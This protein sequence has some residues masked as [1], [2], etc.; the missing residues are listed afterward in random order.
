MKQILFL[1]IL[2]NTLLLSETITN[3]TSEPM[4]CQVNYPA[5]F[6]K[7]LVHNIEQRVMVQKKEEFSLVL[8]PK[9]S[10][11]KA[12]KGS[13]VCFNSLQKISVYSNGIRTE[14]GRYFENFKKEQEAFDIG[15]YAN[16]NREFV[17]AKFGIHRKCTSLEEGEYCQLRNGLDILYTKRGRVKKLLIYGQALYDLDFQ[18]GS[19]H[20]IKAGRNPLGLWVAKKNKKLVSAKPSFQSSN[21]IVWKNPHKYIKSIVLTAKNGHLNLYNYRYKKED[22]KKKTPKDQLGAIEVEY[23]LDDAAYKKH[24]AS[25]PMPQTS[26]PTHNRIDKI[27]LPKK[28]KKTWG[29]YLNPKN[30]IPINKFKAFYIDTNHPKKLIASEIV[31]KVAVNYPWKDFHNIDA[32]NFG[33]Y[34]VGNFIFKETKEQELSVSQ[35]W[36]RTRVIIDGMVVY[37]GGSNKKFKHKF[38]KGKHKI[39]VEYVNNWHTVGFMFTMKDK[40]KLYSIGEIQKELQQKTSKNSVV[41]FAGA[42]ESKRKDQSITL[43]LARS[44]KPVVLVLN[45]YDAVRWIIKNPYKVKLQA[46]VYAAHKP[47]VEI[48]GKNIKSIPLYHSK[49]AIGAYKMKRS[50][51]CVNGGADFHCE[52][53]EP[54]KVLQNIEN[55]IGK[56]VFGYSVAY[57]METVILPNTLINKKK[58]AEFKLAQKQN[59]QM[60]K[61]CQRQSNPDFEKMF[62]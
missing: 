9:R 14:S 61:S 34:W 5:I 32:K 50:C 6:E 25:R 48:S 41:V 20:K 29:K 22:Q 13:V 19:F 53:I 23:L 10:L 46:I 24:Q 8:Q 7:E 17:E 15:I 44:K 40:E 33:G 35:S 38:T 36:A 26:F 2:F 62:E 42:Y 12:R 58:I 37:E 18:A 4:L 31:N 47:G 21:A 54:L 43:K 28:A 3:E 27:D 55:V 30:N 52:G 59:E 45:S 57:G 56:K 16:E 1:L 39:E 60:R 51:T 11:Q 49:R